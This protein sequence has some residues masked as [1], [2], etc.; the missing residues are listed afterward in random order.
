ME[1]ALDE[2]GT[3]DPAF[4][5][6]D[7]AR[8]VK[9][10]KNELF[11]EIDYYQSE[12]VYHVFNGVYYEHS[13]GTESLIN[14]L[15]YLTDIEAVYLR[16]DFAVSCGELTA[17]ERNTLITSGGFALAAPVDRAP[18]N[19]L[20]ESGYPF[21]GGQMTLR[22]RF[23]ATGRETALKLDG[24]FTLAK[25]SVNG[26]DQQTLMFD[27]VADI[28][29]LVKP[30]ENTLEITLFSSYRNVFGPFHWAASPEPLSVSPDLFSGYGTWREDG[31]SEKYNPAYAFT[32]F[33]LFG[34]FIG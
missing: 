20:T 24:R 10:G 4:V 18:A 34:L 13:D 2:Q 26:S 23:D 14:C 1:I 28:A 16:G 31:T 3:F 19:V 7:I 15:S 9:V 6:A 5:S 29:G 21:F 33:G 11:Y 30:G 12:E 25:V 32:R 22:F 17:G 27:N 8:L